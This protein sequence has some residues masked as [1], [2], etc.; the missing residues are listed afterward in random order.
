MLRLTV[1]AAL[2]LVTGCG[3][4]PTAP[5]EITGQLYAAIAHRD[6]AA[7][8]ASLAAATRSALEHEEQAPCQDAILEQGVPN[9]SGTATAKV[10][11]SMAQVAYTN[12]TVFL[13]RY[14]DGWR[15]TAAGCTPMGHDRPYECALTAN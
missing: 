12:E 5:A 9:A 8:C 1:A 2:L 4:A 7:A 15:V 6:A 14:S 3:P 13:S 11:G 10:Y